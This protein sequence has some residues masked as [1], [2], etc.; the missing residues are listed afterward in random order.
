MQEFILDYS[1]KVKSKHELGM[2]EGASRERL[3]TCH[4]LRVATRAGS[5][6]IATVMSPGSFC[7]FCRHM[8]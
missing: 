3:K 5:V 2:D 4:K 6:C 8:K 1:S 7:G